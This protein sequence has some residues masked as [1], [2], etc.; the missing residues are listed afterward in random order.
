MS[1]VYSIVLLGLMCLSGCDERG[2]V[3]REGSPIWNMRHA[4]AEATNAYFETKCQTY[5]YEIGTDALRDCIADERR[6]MSANSSRRN[7]GY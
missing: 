7:S 2:G 5:G 6:N 3:G 4:S 1:K